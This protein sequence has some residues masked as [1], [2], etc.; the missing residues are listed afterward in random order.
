MPP[1]QEHQCENQPSFVSVN[2][3]II[4][5][6]PENFIQIFIPSFVK[7]KEFQSSPENPFLRVIVF[8]SK[9]EKQHTHTIETVQNHLIQPDMCPKGE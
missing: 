9:A 5:L 4:A 8:S 2:F 7:K 3:V 1:Q 6:V